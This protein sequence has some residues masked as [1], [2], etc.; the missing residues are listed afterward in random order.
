VEAQKWLSWWAGQEW[1]SASFGPIFKVSTWICVTKLVYSKGVSSRLKIL[2]PGS[3]SRAR[4]SREKGAFRR[5][6]CSAS[7]IWTFKASKW[8]HLMPAFRIHTWFWHCRGAGAS[9]LRCRETRKNGFG[10]PGWFQGWIFRTLCAKWFLHSCTKHICI[11]FRKSYG[12]SL[13][14]SQ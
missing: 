1:K 6:T 4:T 11:Q 5:L 3:R 2:S 9:I 12:Q 13:N 14:G 10:P 7:A 8:L